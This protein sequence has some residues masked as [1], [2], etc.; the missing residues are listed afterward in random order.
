MK[1]WLVV[2][3]CVSS[4]CNDF[5]P[6]KDENLRFQTVTACRDYIV[7]EVEKPENVNLMALCKVG[8]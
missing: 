7:N 6:K 5:D 1:I 4:Y 8:P 3:L 2:W